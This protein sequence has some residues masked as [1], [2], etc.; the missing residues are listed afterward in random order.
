MRESAN[1][2]KILGGELLDL[3]ERRQKI[4]AFIIDR[5]ILT[6]EPVGSKAI[7]EEIDMSISSATIR[8]EMSELVDLGYLEQ[9]H[10][11][12]GRIPSQ[13]GYRYYVDNLIGRY[14]LASEERYRI[15]NLL[16]KA[17]GEPESVLER[18]SGLLAELTGCAAVST[19][20]LDE[21]SVIQK[22]ELVPIGLRTAMIVLVTSSGLL[23]SRVCRFDSE[24]TIEIVELFYNIAQAHF[25]KNKTAEI[26]T[27]IIQT[28]AA[29]LGD[30]AFVMIPLLTALYDLSH[31]A[32]QSELLLE[33]EANLL[34]NR[35]LEASACKLLEFLQRGEPLNQLLTSNRDALSILIGRENTYKEMENSS[36]ILSRYSIGGQDVGSLGIIGPTRIDYARLIPSIKYLSD[37]VSRF[38]SDALEY[39]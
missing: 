36:M 11:S 19:T 37:L 5:Y 17:S 26:N 10:T 16:E 13:K 24:I 15:E 30:K 35:D 8:N 34:N 3:N 1:S 32:A 28:I 7:S 20:P 14:E 12:S 23:K 39:G 38:L 31:S 18:A 25:I 21:F 27:V 4:L 9:P 2:A 29:S 33:G 22:V 6:G